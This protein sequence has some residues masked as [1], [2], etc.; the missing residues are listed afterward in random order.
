MSTSSRPPL[1][2]SP[3]LHSLRPPTVD[4]VS[5]E[6][7]TCCRPP[8]RPPSRTFPPP[9]DCSHLL[10]RRSPFGCRLLLPHL[11]ALP[12]HRPS[13]AQSGLLIRLPTRIRAGRC[14][15]RLGKGG[16]AGAGKGYEPP[17]T[18]N[19]RDGSG[20]EGRGAE[21]VG[22]SG[23]AGRGRGC[24]GKGSAPILLAGIRAGGLFSV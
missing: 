7:S 23:E 3:P 24:G 19:G 21:I 2:S 15:A 1:S 17:S 12:L 4:I 9:P 11:R 14:L 18:P 10:L 20:L 5:D 16:E 8:L 13:T 22:R 6:L